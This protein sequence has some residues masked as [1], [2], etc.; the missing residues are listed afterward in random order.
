MRRLSLFSIHVCKTHFPAASWFL[1]QA[2]IWTCANSESR[3]WSPNLVGVLFKGLLSPSA[4]VP[5]EASAYQCN[6]VSTLSSLLLWFTQNMCF[7]I[8]F[9]CNLH[10]RRHAQK[11]YCKPM[12]H[13]GCVFSKLQIFKSNDNLQS[14]RIT[15]RREATGYANVAVQK[16]CMFLW[17]YFSQRHDC[18]V[19]RQQRQI[20][21]TL[22]KL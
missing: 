5:V 20:F 22:S 17:S 6:L 13:I 14:V 2:L 19:R 4:F 11:L 1:L 9:Y 15:V 21:N 10:E 7:F 18:R 16:C 12:I 3:P 8:C